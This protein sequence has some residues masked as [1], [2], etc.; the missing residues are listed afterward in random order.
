MPSTT[1]MKI[2][3]ERGAITLQMSTNDRTSPSGK[4]GR[5]SSLVAHWVQD[6]WAHSAP[7][8]DVLCV[9]R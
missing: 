8:H 6:V 2:S 7:V 1:K 9:R 3:G 5:F 4:K